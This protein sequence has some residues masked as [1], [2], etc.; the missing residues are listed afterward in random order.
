MR[1]TQQEEEGNMERREAVRGAVRAVLDRKVQGCRDMAAVLR[2]IGIAVDGGTAA[3]AQQVSAAYKQA[4]L[5]FHPDRAAGA[6]GGADAQAQV[7]AEE[8]FKLIVKL[9]GTLPMA[10]VPH[11]PPSYAP[12]WPHR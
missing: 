9:K 10:I 4:L 8:T 3:T 12:A 11:S 6:G 7:E 5:R 1:R 2:R